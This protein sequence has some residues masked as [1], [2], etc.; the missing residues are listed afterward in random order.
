MRYWIILTLLVFQTAFADSYKEL[1]DRYE[2]ATSNEEKAVLADEMLKQA[3]EDRNNYQNKGLSR[4]QFPYQANTNDD[5]ERLQ[6]EKEHQL[7]LLRQQ[8]A[9]E[10]ELKRLQRKAAWAQFRQNL[11][12]G[13][14]Q[15]GQNIQQQQAQQQMIN[16]LNRPRYTNCYGGYNSVNCMSY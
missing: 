11:G 5:A 7:E 14:M 9:Y 6:L 15:A 10:E 13:L 2:K 4:S 12:F 3:I 8:A 1:A 16:Q